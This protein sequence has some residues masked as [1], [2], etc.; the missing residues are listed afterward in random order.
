M[1]LRI[2]AAVAATLSLALTGCSS[3]ALPS[4]T[5]APAP[6]ASQAIPTVTPDPALRAQLP[7]KVRDAGKIVIGV[8]PTYKPNEYLDADGKTVLGMDVELF[9]AVA[10]RLGVTTEWQPSAFDQ[11]LIGIDARKYDAGVSSFTIND[12]RKQSVNFVSYL[13]AGSQWITPAGN[14]KGLDPKNLC[15]QTVAIQTGTVQDDEMQA[16]NEKCAPD[17]KINV[18]SFADQGEVTNAVTS[19]RAAGMS[20]DSPISLYAAKMS[21]GKLAPLGEVYDSAPYGFA[22]HKADTAF[23]EAVAQATRDI[24][25]AGVYDAVLAKYGQEKSAVTDIAVNP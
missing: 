24:R 13:D 2:A 25:A 17:K 10:H 11:I 14:P 3:T 16:A 23:A 1:K 5:A 4:N 6:A 7:Q 8:D 18:L 15:C 12:E 21:N 9:D 20:A 22:F 19:G